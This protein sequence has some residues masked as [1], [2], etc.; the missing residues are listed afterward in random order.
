MNSNGD[1]SGGA[2]ASRAPQLSAA[3]LPEPRRILSWVYVGRLCLALA[4]FLAALL[5]WKNAPADTTLSAT[6]ILFLSG[7]FTAGSFWHSHLAR[8]VPGKNFLYAQVLFDVVMVTWVIHLTG[9]P[10]SAFAPLYILVICAAAVLL[11]MLGGILMGL[12]A[13][14]MYFADI[15]LSAPHALLAPGVLLQTALFATVA[16]VTGYLG[17]RLRQTGT[18][19]GE[20]E[21]E[22]RLLRLDTDEIL[23][24]MNS[25]ILTVDG[26]GR[27]VYMNPAAA[28]IL[29]LTRE[30]WEGQP[31]LD[32]L[33]RAA[34]GLGAI[35]RR[36]AETRQPIRRSETHGTSEAG[37]ILGVST[38]LMERPDPDGPPVTAIFQDIT[39]RMRMESLRRRAERLEAVAELSASLAHEIKNPLASI[40]SAVEQ[41]TGDGV[42]AEDKEVLERLVV[43]ESDRLSRLLAEFIDFARVRV[44]DAAPVRVAQVVSHAVDMVRAHPDASGRAIRLLLPD[45]PGP[46]VRGDEDLLHRAVANLVLNGA[47]WAGPGGEVEVSLDTVQS[48]VL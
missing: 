38:T 8:A 43:R 44:R 26:G 47:Q 27:L 29:T 32:E 45:E 10:G 16:M 40:R 42:D 23:G 17:D 46:A 21:T 2:R 12:L 25:G 11:P 13:S 9:G 19:L 20:I 14:I 39:E 6:L 36:S 7:A 4:I 31:V 34:P 41:L 5:A 48:D 1:R 18:V 28:E 3:R 33:E 15:A 22:L 35:I 24:S 37:T 30:E